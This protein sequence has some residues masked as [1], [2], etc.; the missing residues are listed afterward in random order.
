MEDAA[1]K[2][3]EKL[4]DIVAVPPLLN[5]SLTQE[6]DNLQGAFACFVEQTLSSPAGVAGGRVG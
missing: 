1:K 3:Q 4:I 5:N 2:Q 6:A